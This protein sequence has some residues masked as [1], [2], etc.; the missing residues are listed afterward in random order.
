MLGRRIGQNFVDPNGLSAYTSCRLVAME[1]CP[2]VRPIRIGDVVQ[3]IIGKA[4]LTVTSQDTQLVTGALQ[5]SGQQA[6]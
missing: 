3:R 1:N 2:S 5:L 4:I 6:G